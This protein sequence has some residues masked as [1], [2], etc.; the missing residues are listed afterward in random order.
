MCESFLIDYQIESKIL[1]L[2]GCHKWMDGR[3]ASA[4]VVLM[5]SLDDV[6]SALWMP[7][8]IRWRLFVILL[9]YVAT[10]DS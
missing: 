3:L 7:F 4:S 1:K 5:Q 9:I 10:I 8:V 2:C 6:S